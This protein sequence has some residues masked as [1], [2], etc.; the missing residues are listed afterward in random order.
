MSQRSKSREIALQG[1]YQYEVGA[2][3]IDRILTC[4][5]V[6]NVNP[7][8]LDNVLNFAK[9]LIQKTINH[10]QE[11]DYLIEKNLNNW[12]INKITIVDKS[13]LRFSTYEIIYDQEIPPIVTINEAVHLAKRFGKNNSYIFINGV[14]DSI[15]NKSY[16][17]T[18][19]NNQ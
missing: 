8:I 6:Q 4:F 16:K 19:G 3:D 7:S 18:K 5:W 12:K 13:I 9:N 2:M 14:L 11:I 15:K 17:I 1:L 10:I